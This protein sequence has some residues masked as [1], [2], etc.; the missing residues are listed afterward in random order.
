MQATQTAPSA[1]GPYTAAASVSGSYAV[2]VADIA[3]RQGSKITV[4]YTVTATDAAGNT[5]AATTLTF[6]DAK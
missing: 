5:S 6:L 3:G 2:T 1:S 4:T